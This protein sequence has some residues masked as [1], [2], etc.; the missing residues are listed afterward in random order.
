MP[1]RHKTPPANLSGTICRQKEP[2]D[3]WVAQ[4]GFTIDD[5]Q[6]GGFFVESSGSRDYGSHWKRHARAEMFTPYHNF[7]TLQISGAERF[8][9]CKCVAEPDGAIIPV[10]GNIAA[11]R[12]TVSDHQQRTVRESLSRCALAVFAAV[13][14]GETFCF[15]Q[16]CPGQESQDPPA[17]TATDT[18]ID[19]LDSNFTSRWQCFSSRK[20]KAGDTWRLVRTGNQK[21][22]YCSGDP[23]GFLITSERYTNFELTFEWMYPEDANGNSG[24]LIYTRNEPRL[25][26]TSMQVQLHRPQAGALFATGDAVSDKPFDAGLEGKAGDWNKCRIVSLNG[27]L[28]VEINGQRAGQA[29]GCS[30][31]SGHIALQSEGSV[32]LFRNLH[33][34]KL[35]PVANDKEMPA[36]EGDA[37]SGDDQSQGNT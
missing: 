12:T 28:S 18:H 37:G 14:I 31:A 22:L 15:S 2:L 21:H 36:N 16:Q 5:L 30:P 17:S 3:S 1:R 6:K 7:A 25:W 11:N 34:K 29:E 19:L 9:N 26:P 27:Q 4:P 35:K 8:R 24:V 32:T 23:K 33:L 13:L 20:G 10:G